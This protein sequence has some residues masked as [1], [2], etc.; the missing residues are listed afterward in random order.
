MEKDL[1]VIEEE[2]LDRSQQ[3][4]LATLKAKC[5]LGYIKRGVVGWVKEV[6]YSALVKSN[7]EFCVQT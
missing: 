4:I 6:F 5:I 7:L 3:Y 1:Q 2:K